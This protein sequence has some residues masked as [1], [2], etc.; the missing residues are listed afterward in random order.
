MLLYIQI[1]IYSETTSQIILRLRLTRRVKY[2]IDD[3]NDN[4]DRINPLKISSTALFSLLS[5]RKLIHVT[6]APQDVLMAK[7]DKSS[8]HNFQYRVML[9]TG[10][11]HLSKNKED[12]YLNYRSLL[13]R[14]R[15]IL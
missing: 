14:I 3:Y 11:I 10:S 15:Y 4:D 7:M 6:G 8:Q 13:Y 9:I 12:P 1:I 2:D 5:Y